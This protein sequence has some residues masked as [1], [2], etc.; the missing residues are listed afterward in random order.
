MIS[1]KTYLGVFAA[2][3]ALTLVTTGVAYVD[4]GGAWNIVAALT[5]AGAKTLAVALYFMHLRYSGRLT[6]LFAGAGVFWLAILFALTL[7]DYISRGWV[8]AFEAVFG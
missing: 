4:L 2:L 6:V 7:S 1:V 5:I 8:S 3:L